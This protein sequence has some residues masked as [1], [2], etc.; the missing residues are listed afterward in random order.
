MAS[1]FSYAEQA[2]HYFQRPHETVAREPL[3]VPA[4]WRGPDLA[5]SDSW[6]VR[7]DAAQREEIQAAPDVRVVHPRPPALDVDLLEAEVLAQ[8]G[9]LLD[10]ILRWAEDQRT[11]VDEV[12]R[13]LL[14]E[15]F[16]L[17]R[18]EG[19][20]GIVTRRDLRFEKT[21]VFISNLH[22]DKCFMNN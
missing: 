16:L 17:P 7:L 21:I 3:R 9:E 20:A 8:L 6:R 18:C 4:A 5:G 15:C 19:L 11:L 14:L 12:E 13:Q 1:Y 2:G 10:R 22:K